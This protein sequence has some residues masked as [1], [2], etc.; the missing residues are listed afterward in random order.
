MVE[1]NYAEYAANG[2]R[3]QNMSAVY[4]NYVYYLPM[5]Q[6]LYT[7]VRPSELQAS[8]RMTCN[9]IF[10]YIYILHLIQL[11]KFLYQFYKLH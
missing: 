4:I 2:H 6:P 10:N 11:F 5:C 7:S 9:S 3:A 8:R 1:P